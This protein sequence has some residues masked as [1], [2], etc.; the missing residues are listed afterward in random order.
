MQLHR[1]YPIV[2]VGV[3]Q[4]PDGETSRFT[5]DWGRRRQQRLWMRSLFEPVRFTETGGE[6]D[7]PLAKCELLEG[8]L[9]IEIDAKTCWSADG[10]PLT[11]TEVAQ[12]ILAAWTDQRRDVPLVWRSLLDRVEPT[13]V[14][15]LKVFWRTVPP[16]WPALLQLAPV[17][18]NRMSAG[19]APYHLAERAAGMARFVAGD[20]NSSDA[21]ASSS[22]PREIIE[23]RIGSTASAI[24]A[25]RRKQIQV[26]DRLP[27]W[28]LPN[29]RRYEELEIKRYAAPTVHLLVVNPNSEWLAHSLFR[30]GLVHALQRREILK[31]LLG[32]DAAS[33]G[34]ILSGP[35]PRGHAYNAAVA[36]RDWDPRLAIGLW[37]NAGVSGRSADDPLALK[38]VYPPSETARRAS[39]VMQQQ[40]RLN[41]MGINL[42]LRELTELEQDAGSA[43]DW[44]LKYVEWPAMEPLVDAARLLGRDGLAQVANPCWTVPYNDWRRPR[45]PPMRR[46]SCTKFINWS[47]HKLW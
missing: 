24:E 43:D 19:L 36:P 6:Y 45:R 5:L 1:E 15:T 46:T 27:P 33:A 17:H 30:R 37:Q 7:S 4:L 13:E 20:L 35:F 22:S 11:S 25:L 21:A 40:L 9:K 31:Q 32:S 16:K 23:R 12:G 3:R 2:E 28:E 47:T 39:R 44:D 29:V 42:Q 41:D 18:L 8:T 14:G 26:Y 34:E 10:Q 38:L